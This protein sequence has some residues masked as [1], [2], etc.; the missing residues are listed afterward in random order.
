MA[1]IEALKKIAYDEDG[2]EYGKSPAGIG[3]WDHNALVQGWP[4][5]QN[6][7]V[8]HGLDVNSKPMDGSSYFAQ[9]MENAKKDPRPGMGGGLLRRGSDGPARGTAALDDLKTVAP[10]FLHGK[11]NNEQITNEDLEKI[12]Y[13]QA[14]AAARRL[15]PE[16]TP[17]NEAWRETLESAGA[18]NLQNYLKNRRLAP[19]AP[20][21]PKLKGVLKGKKL[22]AE[23]QR[24]L[25]AIL[26]SQAYNQ[27]KGSAVKTAQEGGAGIWASL[28][29]WLDQ[30][31]QWLADPKNSAFRPI[32]GAGVGALGLGGLST[33]LG[34]SFGRG[35]LLGGLGGA[36]ATQFDWNA[37]S[38][39]LG[40]NKAAPAA[41]GS[42]TAQN[43]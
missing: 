42:A 31:K 15:A 40:K 5:D 28:S 38:E 37:L 12:R 21:A 3:T 6:G 36:A 19:V 9:L 8:T 13:E 11:P 30:A 17:E 29:S 35:A 23:I 14:R 34:G 2:V 33:L 22:P 43:K 25:P 24:A 4:V 10:I 39:A 20:V 1:N 41:Q 7:Y 32:V 26:K 27:G 16:G 18:E